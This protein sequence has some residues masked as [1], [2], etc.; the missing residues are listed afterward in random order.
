[1]QN[2]IIVILFLLITFTVTLRAYPNAITSKNTIIA[3]LETGLFFN[4][5]GVYTPSEAIVHISSIFPM[6][7]A[8]CHFLPLLAAENIPL[9]NITKKRNKRFVEAIIPI[10]SL[11]VAAVGLGLSVFNTIQ[12]VNLQEQITVV[13][14]S[15]ARFSK[16]VDIHQAQLVKLTKKHIELVEELQVTQKALNDIVPVIN[17][18][19]KDINA[20]KTD[21]ELL[22]IRLQLSFLHLA[23]DQI[24]RDEFTLAFL[25]PEDIHKV[26]YHVI[27][28]GNLT[29]NSYP[30]SLPVVQII[31]KLLVRQQIDFVRSAEYTSNSDEIGRLV[32]TSFF[33]VPRQKQTP[34]DVYELVTIPLFQGNEAVQL[35]EISRY[36]AINP[37]NN[38]TI[39]WHNPKESRCDLGLMTSCRDTPPFRKISKD[40]CLDQIIEKLPLSKCR[41][42]SS[43]APKYFLRQ[44]KDNL[45][46]TS[47]PKPIHC[48]R[49]PRT[50]HRNVIN[51]TSNMSEKIVLP[52]VSLVNLTEGLHN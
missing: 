7:T 46:I 17:S 36:W 33:A 50:D 28:E 12:N 21:I 35:A 41:T 15:L 27:K 22:K 24:L 44:I 9:C 38:A 52:P 19:S 26:V 18:H 14:N 13:E 29:F 23:I 20:H 30:G 25:L 43:P 47:S 51:Q 1:M 39:E 34:F 40:T 3:H 10:L 48:V 11:G 8:T 5:V 45:W 6:T 31:T 37:V 42:I 32:I 49:I 2:Y 4:Y 16:M